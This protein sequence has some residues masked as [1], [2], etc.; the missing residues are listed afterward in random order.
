MSI[1]PTKRQQDQAARIV[2][3]WLGPQMREDGKPVE[4]S[5]EAAWNA[6]GVYLNREWDWPDGDPTPTLL[7]EGGPD[8]WAIRAAWELMDEFARIGV[9]AEPYASYALCLYRA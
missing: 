7:L 1:H 9:F 3:K 4:I 8:E 5:K 2:A 6:T